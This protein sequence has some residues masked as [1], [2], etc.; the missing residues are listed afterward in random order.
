MH[1]WPQKGKSE[2]LQLATASLG[3]IPVTLETLTKTYAVLANKGHLPQPNAGSVISETTANSVTRMLEGSVTLGTGKQAAID[4][5]SVAG[6]TGTLVDETN[7]THLALFGGY[8]PANAPRFAMV[9]ILEDGYSTEKNGEKS[10]TGGTLAA[11]V[12]H[13]VAIKVL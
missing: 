12:F 5:I 11:P 13:N 4:G 2:A 1:N 10:T 6:K 3:D 7:G 9:V 8:V